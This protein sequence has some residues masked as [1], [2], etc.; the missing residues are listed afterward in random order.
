MSL[1]VFPKSSSFHKFTLIAEITT[2]GRLVTTTT[3]EHGTKKAG[4][5][6]LPLDVL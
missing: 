3:Y 6:D 4:H 2:P 1:L 5:K